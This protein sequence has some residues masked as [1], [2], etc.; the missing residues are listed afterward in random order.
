MLAELS[1]MLTGE[2][3][4]EV[5]HGSPLL[6]FD[7]S[8]ERRRSSSFLRHLPPPPPPPP[9]LVPL[10]PIPA[11]LPI[12]ARALLLAHFVMEPVDCSVVGLLDRMSLSTTRMFAIDVNLVG[13]P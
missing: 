4:G 9:A 6:E 2:G 5:E 7:E 10:A 1:V 12:A 3:E 8:E 11:L 13:E